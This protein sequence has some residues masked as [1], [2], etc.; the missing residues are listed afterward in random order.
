MGICRHSSL[1]E[2]KYLHVWSYRLVILG[3]DVFNV[4]RVSKKEQRMKKTRRHDFCRAFQFFSYSVPSLNRFQPI[5]S[6]WCDFKRQYPYCLPSIQFYKR[7][8]FLQLFSYGSSSSVFPS[9]S[10]YLKEL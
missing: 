4:V 6:I 2:P 7:K 1:F 3:S 8:V 10:A 5:L 9:F